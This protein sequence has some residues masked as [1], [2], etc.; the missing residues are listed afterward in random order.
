MTRD[1]LLSALLGSIAGVSTNVVLS[2]I[3]RRVNDWQLTRIRVC[4]VCK[5]LRM[6]DGHIVHNGEAIEINVPC[7]IC[8]PV[9][10]FP[11]AT[12]AK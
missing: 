4:K 1:L 6:I 5:G 7:P 8:N 9:G 3:R 11:R 12:P 2:I 10:K